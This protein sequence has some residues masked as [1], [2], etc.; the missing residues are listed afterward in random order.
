MKKGTCM[1]L[2]AAI[3]GGRNE[4]KKGAKKIKKY[5]YRTVEVQRIWNAKQK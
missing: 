2:Q 4:I 3:P 1:L 5:K